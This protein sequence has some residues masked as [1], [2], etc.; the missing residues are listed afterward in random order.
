MLKNYFITALRNIK[1][2]KTF[3]IINIIGLAVG[4]AVCMLIILFVNSE[5]SYDKFHKDY[6]KIFRIQNKYGNEYREIFKTEWGITSPAMLKDLLTEKFPEIKTVTRIRFLDQRRIIVKYNGNITSEKKFLEVDPS[7]FDMFDYEF[8]NGGKSFAF[9]DQNSVVVTKSFAARYFGNDNPLNKIINIKGND[10]KVTAV[11]KDVPS[12]SHLKFDFLYPIVFRNGELGVWNNTNFATYVKLN[13]ATDA[14]SVGGRILELPK[15]HC[16]NIMKSDN[17]FL[18]PIKDI[19]FKSNT[20]SEFEPSGDIN[21]V[22]GLITLALIILF[23]ACINYMNLATAKSSSRS[24]EIGLRKSIGAGKAQI[25]RQFLVES[26]IL[27]FIAMLLSTLIVYLS[28][29][30]FNRLTGTELDINI[31]GNIK[32]IAALLLISAFTGIMAGSYPAFILSSFKPTGVFKMQNSSGGKWKIVS[33]RQALILFQFTVSSFLIIGVIVVTKQMHYINNKDLGYWKDQ[34]VILPNIDYR[35]KDQ[36]KVFKNELLKYPFVQSASV[37]YFIPA[38]VE[39]KQNYFWD[40]PQNDQMFSSN[41]VDEDYFKTYNIKLA[42]GR[43]FSALTNDSKKQFILNESAVKYMKLDQ[44]IGIKIGRGDDYQGEVVG[45]VKDFHFKS[46]H[47]KIAPIIMSWNAN[48]FSYLSIKLNTKNMASSLSL[49]KAK[50]NE[51]I[52]SKPFIYSFFDED[53]GKIYEKEI[54]LSGIVN[55]FSFLSIFI[56]CLG[57]MGLVAFAIEKRKKEI[58]I[59]KVLGAEMKNVLYLISKEFFFLTLIANVIA[60]PIAYS[61]MS[62]WL[63]DFAYKTEMSWWIFA[64]SILIS[65][66]L[67]VLTIGSQVIRAASANPVDSLRNE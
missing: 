53:F 61:V 6:N 56:A 14:L 28:I 59:R 18:M 55:T 20:N 24:N 39:A 30:L 49:I 29:P 8:I 51:I 67:S 26:L 12:N 10:Y 60:I 38:Q 34:I 4:M 58:S 3:S 52:N 48:A 31:L 46:F 66:S 57:L 33:F 13:K 32:F 9:P 27:S 50:F 63:S 42:Q 21:L 16:S 37:S 40:N 15:Y 25:I 2:Y 62:G 23:L 17:L 35:L 11:L 5:I 44:P 45:V 19:H 41:D 65:I 47:E 22:Y 43:F 54:R 1:R 7:F 36:Y 64:V